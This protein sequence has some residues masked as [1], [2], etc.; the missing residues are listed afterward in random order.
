MENKRIVKYAEY[1]F[2]GIFFAGIFVFFAFFYNN[3][4]HFEEQFQ[5]FL[6]TDSYFLEKMGFPGGFSG[7]TGGF[8]TQFYYLSWAG[9]LVIACLLFALQ[10]V[11][12]Q[13]LKTINSNPIFSP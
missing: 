11:T 3:H 7:W 10:R 2:S 4:L 6:L 9:P 8:L 1:M 5:L 13:V 12:R